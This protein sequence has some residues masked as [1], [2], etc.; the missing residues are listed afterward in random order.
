MS[1]LEKLKAGKKNIKVLKFPGTE[2][3]V[4][5]QLL[6]NHDLQESVFAAENYFKKAGIEI[7]S[8]VL[9]SYEDE[10][11]TQLLFRALKDPARP[12]NPFAAT[13]DEL[14]RNLTKEEKEI[15]TDE[16]LQF[17]RE[18]SPN[19]R[20][21]S[22]EEFETLWVDLKKNPKAILSSLP[23]IMLRRLLLYL[24]SQQASSPTDSG[25]TSSG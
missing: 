8:T 10:R 16:Y 4:G 7:V 18:C 23:S 24:A 2:E 15:L 1:L 12:Q 25:S 11:T 14:R 19:F 22:D 5:L 17:E 13:V 21:M 6:S 3:D 20:Q 9:D